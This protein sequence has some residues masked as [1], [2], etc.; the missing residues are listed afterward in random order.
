MD[1]A[2]NHL[3][4]LYNWYPLSSQE[5]E[6]YDSEK[7]WALAKVWSLLLQRGMILSKWWWI[8]MYTR[9]KWGAEK[10]RRC[11]GSSRIC[12]WTDWV[13][14]CEITMTSTK[15]NERGFFLLKSAAMS[16]IISLSE[17]Q[18]LLIFN[19]EKN[20]FSKI[21][22]ETSFNLTLCSVSQGIHLTI[23]KSSE[24]KQCKLL[25]S[26]FQW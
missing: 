13:H 21:L 26:G 1:I 23:N 8:N 14:A 6:I 15:L 12:F 22:S 16:E 25:W 20:Y 19:D 3:S 7:S 10:V 11:Y 2:S 18:H 5:Y 24:S 9:R 17:K 4:L